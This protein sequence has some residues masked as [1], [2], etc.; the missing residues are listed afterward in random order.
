VHGAVEHGE[1]WESFVLWQ[2]GGRWPGAP[3][4]ISDFCPGQIDPSDSP[5][6]TDMGDE[7]ETNDTNGKT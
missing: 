2:D 5:T 1:F 7:Y 3:N 4:Y 6:S